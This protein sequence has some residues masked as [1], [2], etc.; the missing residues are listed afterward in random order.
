MKRVA[1]L[2]AV[3]L[4]LHAHA[5]AATIELTTKD[6]RSGNPDLVDREWGARLRNFGVIGDGGEIYIGS[7]T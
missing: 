7:A 5:F 3:V 2:L 1:L 6:P 4:C